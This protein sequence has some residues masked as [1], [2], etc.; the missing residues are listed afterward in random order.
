M[1]SMRPFWK[2]FRVE[3]QTHIA[4]NHVIEKGLSLFISAHYTRLDANLG[5]IGD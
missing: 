3:M 1:V 2:A 4:L 5:I